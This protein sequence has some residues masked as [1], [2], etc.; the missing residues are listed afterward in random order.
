MRVLFV[1]HG[2][3]CRSPMAEFVLRRSVKE[4]GMS[5]DV[6]SVGISDEEHGGP[7]DFRAQQVLLSAGYSAAELDQHRARLVKPA[8]L[9][10]AFVVAMEERHRRALHQLSPNMDVF[11]LTDFDPEASAGDPVTDPWYGDLS[12]FVATLAQLER[13]M[14]ALIDALSK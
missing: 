3:I 12:G 13:A 11:L 10:N 1:C 9:C 6:A 7:L 4:A 5:V 8:D 14:P 2:N